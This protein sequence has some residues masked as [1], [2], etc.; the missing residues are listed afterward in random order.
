[1]VAGFCIFAVALAFVA[2]WGNFPLNDDWVYARN[3][4]ASAQAGHLRIISPQYAW[5]IPQTVIGAMIASGSPD[6]HSSLRWIGIVSLLVS[7][8]LLFKVSPLRRHDSMTS[9]SMAMT[10]LFLT[11]LFVVSLSF[12]SD[13]PFLACWIAS[14][15]AWIEWSRRPDAPTLIIALA[16]SIFSVSQRQFGLLVSAAMGAVLALEF[17]RERNLRSALRMLVPVPVLVAYFL[18][19]KWWTAHAPLAHAPLDLTLSPVYIFRTAFTTI[20]HL[21]MLAIPLI[22]MPLS[23][24]ARRILKNRKFQII[25]GLF[26]FYTLGHHLR[27]GH[28][29]PYLI[30]QMSRFGFF[31]PGEVLYGDREPIFGVPLEIL[32]TLVS[33]VGALRLV[34]GTLVWIRKPD[35]SRA[36]RVVLVSSLIYFV[37]SCFRAS[38]FDRYALP[39]IPFALHGLAYSTEETKASR[40]ARAAGLAGAL[41]LVALSTS[42]VHDYFR[43]NEARWAAARFAMDLGWPA[44]QVGAGYEFFGE[45]DASAGAPSRDPHSYP[46]VASFSPLPGFE[47][48]REFRYRSAWHPRGASIHLL[49]RLD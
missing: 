1:M 9:F 14:L 15:W 46:V 40:F 2:P 43:W 37:I 24:D 32:L 35:H 33:L 44:K 22:A 25:Y 48:I 21:G 11:P 17:L 36:E 16:L 18:I 4:D 10:A 49:K 8:L 30:N 27:S 45:F 34:L 13:T 39:L 41:G 38:F 12:M 20:S 19:Q 31:G 29:F 3:V 47:L 42:L 23:L 5:A 28:P 26:I 6:L 7:W